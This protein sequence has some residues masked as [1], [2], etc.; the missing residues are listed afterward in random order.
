MANSQKQVVLLN[1]ADGVARVTLNR[2]AKRNALNS[3]LIAGL[4]DALRRA[5]EDKE[6]RAI[7]LMGEGADFCSGAD[8][9]ALETIANASVEEN[10]DDARSLMELFVL[11]RSVAP[12]VIAAVRGRALAG[13]CGLA[14]ACDIVLAARSSRFGY[15]EVKIGFV[16]AMVMAILRRNVS[17]KRAFELVTLGEEIGADEAASF[18]LVNH[19]LDDEAFEEEVDVFVQK[20]MKTSSSAVALTKKLLYR[21]DAMSFEDALLLGMDE[22]VIARMSEDC[23]KGIERF[24]KKK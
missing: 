3:E 11:I 17:E 20:F 1:V 6:V 8:L 2:P 16:P 4:K 7:I 22:N 19:V 12:P 5:G 18:G 23:R 21:T 14:T 24:L 15:P 9:A 10:L 13:G